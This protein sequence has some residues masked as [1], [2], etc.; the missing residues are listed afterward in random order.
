MILRTSGGTAQRHLEHVYQKP[1]AAILTTAA[2]RALLMPGIGE[3]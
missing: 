1:G 2:L 3:P